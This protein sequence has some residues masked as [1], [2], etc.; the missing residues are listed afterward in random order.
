MI[1]QL[2]GSVIN[3]NDIIEVTPI[4]S[5]KN[6]HIKHSFEVLLKK[7]RSFKVTKNTICFLS[8]IPQDDLSQ[9]KVFNDLQKLKKCKEYLDPLEHLQQTRTKLIEYWKGDKIVPINIT[10]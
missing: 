3:S 9:F 2:N 5:S 4:V 1:I 10:P 6:S 8:A 7:K